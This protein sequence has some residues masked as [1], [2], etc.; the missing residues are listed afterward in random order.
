[1]G[2][3]QK[4][5]EAWKKPK[6]NMRELW[7]TRLIHWRRG[8]ATVKLEKP[9]RLDKAR[10]LGYKAKQG[11]FVVRQRVLR[12][13]HF[14]EK[15]RSGRKP[16]RYGTR[17]DLSISY[18]VIAEQRAHKKFPNC[19]VLNSY[20]TAEDGRF[21]WYEVIMVDTAHP[22]VKADK[23][24]RWIS[25]KQHRGRAMRGLTSAARKS[26]GMRRKGKGTEKLRPSKKAHY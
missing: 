19:E 6:Q 13:G 10:S 4:I 2:I 1:M 8:P 25:G 21:K 23:N 7:K 9:T 17:K 20:W 26:R 24:L 22:S 3:Y 5:R 14:R 16:R 18:Q 12:G 15:F 11:V